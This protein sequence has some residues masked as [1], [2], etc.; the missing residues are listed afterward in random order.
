MIEL[1]DINDKGFVLNSQLIEL[2]E[3]IPETKITLTTGKYFLVK[4]SFQEVIDKV[5][6]FNRRVY[7]AEREIRVKSE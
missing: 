1:K 3:I 5:V 7:G 2:I 4:D 6:D